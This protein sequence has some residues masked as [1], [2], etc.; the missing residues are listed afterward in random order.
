MSLVGARLFFFLTVCVCRSTQTQLHGMAARYEHDEV[1]TSE[2]NH[3]LLVP[4]HTPYHVKRIISPS[5]LSADNKEWH[6]VL[7]PHGKKAPVKP[8]ADDE[9]PRCSTPSHGVEGAVARR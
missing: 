5:R 7:D 6:C 3:D 1:L 4:R 9:K 2:R 8:T